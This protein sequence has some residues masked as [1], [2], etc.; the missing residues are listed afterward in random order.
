MSTVLEL[1]KTASVVN[2]HT[3]Q[4]QT[5]LFI[6][7]KGDKK[8]HKYPRKC[9]LCSY[10]KCCLL[11]PSRKKKTVTSPN[12]TTNYSNLDGII[13]VGGSVVGFGNRLAKE[14]RAFCWRTASMITRAAIDSTIGTARGT[15]HGS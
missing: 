15:T 2:F 5:Y 13:I 3:P 11:G 8:K 4:E 14:E 10:I 1:L 12:K 9:E 6:Y 7:M